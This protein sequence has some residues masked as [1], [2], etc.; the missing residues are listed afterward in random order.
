[1]V[2]NPIITIK[3][4][5]LARDYTSLDARFIE[6]IERTQNG[7]FTLECPNVEDAMKFNNEAQ[8]KSWCLIINKELED[9]HDPDRYIPLRV[10][11]GLQELED[12]DHV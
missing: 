12:E 11:S 10:M 8:A 9:H 4:Y 7:I 6:K 5:V 2:K 3:G 1:M